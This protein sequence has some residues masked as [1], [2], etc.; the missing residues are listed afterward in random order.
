MN[1]L[2]LALA[3]LAGGGLA[4]ALVATA[5]KRA[6][7]QRLGGPLAQALAMAQRLAAQEPAPGAPPV[8][9]NT[10]IGHLGRVEAA[11]CANQA[12]RQELA[13]LRDA[14]TA[15]WATLQA[16]RGVDE[17]AAAVRLQHARESLAGFG[18]A[19]RDS[20]QQARQALRLSQDAETAAQRGAALVAE[21]ASAIEGVDQG[22]RRITDIVAAIDRLAFQTNLLA[23]NAAVEAARAGEQGRGFAVVAAEVRGLAQR[24]TEAAREIKALIQSNSER[25]AALGTLAA[26]AAA[27]MAA[28]AVSTQQAA[29]ATAAIDATGTQLGERAGTLLEGLQSPPSIERRSPQRATNV[30][31]PD[32]LARARPAPAAEP[33][34]AGEP[35]SDRVSTGR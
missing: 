13:E 9:G 14:A 27:A 19:L 11:L 33:A 18:T 16:A 35:E 23:L 20:A 32:F 24:S 26:Q 25:V 7:A 1:S 6:L 4:A 28:T 17:Q 5:A 15:Q 3:A 31:R 21:A 22:S 8:E 30:T 29:A 2:W 12:A 10:L 34:L